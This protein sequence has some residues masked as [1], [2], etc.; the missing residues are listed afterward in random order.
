MM[1]E[2]T[3]APRVKQ[4]ID[5]SCCSPSP[6]SGHLNQ[7]ILYSSSHDAVASVADAVSIFFLYFLFGNSRKKYGRAGIFIIHVSCR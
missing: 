2:S 1:A 3:G 6:S 7:T 4:E 5:S